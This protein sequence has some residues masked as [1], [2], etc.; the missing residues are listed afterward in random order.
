MED[1]FKMGL[2]S[3]ACTAWESRSSSHGGKIDLR[4]I[5]AE[6]G[7]S[8]GGRGGDFYHKYMRI[9]RR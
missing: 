5:C 6:G 3:G 9:A 2:W 1:G 4:Q 8:G 7:G